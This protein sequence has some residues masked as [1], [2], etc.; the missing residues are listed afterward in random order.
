MRAENGMNSNGARRR[1]RECARAEGPLVTATKLVTACGDWWKN[2]RRKSNRFWRCVRGQPEFSFSFLTEYGKIV[3]KNG[4][5]EKFL[6]G[7][8]VFL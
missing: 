1:V 4:S 8:E 3:R 6:S 2:L 5:A 7:W